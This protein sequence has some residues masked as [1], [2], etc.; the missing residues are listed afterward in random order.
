MFRARQRGIPDSDGVRV[1]SSLDD[2]T[3]FYSS[4]QM[5]HHTVAAKLSSS[6]EMSYNHAGAHEREGLTVDGGL[7]VDQL[8]GA[9]GVTVGEPGFLRCWSS[10]Q[11][12]RSP[13]W[14]SRHAARG[15]RGELTYSRS[16]TSRSAQVIGGAAL[17][18]TC[19]SRRIA[20]GPTSQARYRYSVRA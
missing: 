20:L 2:D 6:C 15:R 17:W 5:R 9:R 18:M 19:R 11:V 8:G 7:S 1:F 13:G 16:Q 14:P 12:A 4:L 3:C 10:F